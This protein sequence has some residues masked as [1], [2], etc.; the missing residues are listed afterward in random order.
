MLQFVAVGV[1]TALLLTVATAWFSRRAASEEAIAQ[2]E[3]VTELLAHSVVQPRI[4]KGL[5]RGESAPVDRFD[6]LVRNRVLGGEVLRVKVWRA[7][8]TIVYSDEPRLNGKQFGLD[9]EELW[10]I[11]TG[12]TETEISDLSDDENRYDQALGA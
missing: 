6:M 9:D 2:A 1:L 3:V 7:D 8:G 4:P 10:A 5:L 11:E 12:G